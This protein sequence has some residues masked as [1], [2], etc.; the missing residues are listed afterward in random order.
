[1]ETCG[2]DPLDFFCR[3][4]AS[5]SKTLATSSALELLS[6]LDTC[7]RR[8]LR[9]RRVY[10]VQVSCPSA[11]G[12]PWAN[13]D[14]EKEWEGLRLGEGAV[15][16]PARR[17][18]YRTPSSVRTHVSVPTSDDLRVKDV[19][20]LR[21][22]AQRLLDCARARRARRPRVASWETRK[23]EAPSRPFRRRGARAGL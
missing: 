8:I 5:G 23:L 2:D 16:P 14:P 13:A 10:A 12:C 1:M 21:V 20:E 22:D 15:T 7:Y 18:A 9:T 17:M 6:T 19:R 4:H 3:A 11:G